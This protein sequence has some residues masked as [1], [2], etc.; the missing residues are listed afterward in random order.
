MVSVGVFWF[1][2]DRV[3]GKVEHLSKR[4]RSSV[5]KIDSN[6]EH[7]HL[8]E[9]PGALQEVSDLAAHHEYWEFPRGRVVYDVGRSCYIVYAVRVLLKPYIKARVVDFFGLKNV[10]VSWLAD[11][12]YVTE[13][14]EVRR[15]LGE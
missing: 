5:G 14:E 11:N 4:N 9:I 2:R 6:L 10:E 3:Y 15:L 1:I 8:W 13:P 7:W 12:H